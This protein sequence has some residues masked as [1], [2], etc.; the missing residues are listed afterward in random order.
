MVDLKQ[1]G[2][3]SGL[4][5]EVREVRGEMRSMRRKVDRIE[6]LL[7]GLTVAVGAGSVGVIASPDTA[8]KVLS[9][10]VGAP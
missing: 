8:A 4:A 6:K 3:H 10:L 2:E 9:M 5:V 1:C 7:W